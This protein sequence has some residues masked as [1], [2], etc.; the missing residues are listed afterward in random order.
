M[1]KKQW[2]IP[3]ILLLIS[4]FFFSFSCK[5]SSSANLARIEEKQEVIK[6]YPFSDPD[7]V[8]VIARYSQWA[9]GAKIYPYFFFDKYTNT[10]GADKA[11]TVVRLENPYISVAVLPQVGGKVWGATEKSSNRDFLY[12]NHVLKFR[13]IAMRGP[14]TSGGIEFNF[15][16]VGH[17]PSTATPVDY[18]NRN[19]PDGSVSCTVG[20]MDVSSRTRWSVTIRLPKDKAYFETHGAWFNPTPFSQSY[21]YWSCAAIHAADDLK[22]IFPGQFQIGHDY[23][24]PLKPWPAGDRGRDLSWYRNNDFGD[25]K[26]YFTVGEYNDFYGAWYQNSDAGFGH[27][28][29][30][31]DM[32]GRK[33]WIWDESRGGGIWVDLLTDKDGQYSEP[34][35]GRLLNQSDHEFFKPNG[36]D[37]WREIWFPYRN[38]GPMVKSSPLGVLSVD[39]ADNLFRIGVFALQDIDD[40]LVVRTP[41]N[42][43]YRERLRLKTAES[44][45]KNLPVQLGGE[46]FTVNIGE[47]LIYQSDPAARRLSRPLIF[48]AVDET[49]A[50]G[51]YLGGTR[52]EKERMY[53]AALQKYLECLSME[54]LHLRALARTAELYARRGEYQ[55]AL[56]YAEKALGN[57]M[58]DPE[59]NYIFGIISR[60]LG[61]LVDAKETL[62]WAAR[63]LEFRSSAYTQLGEISLFEKNFSQAADYARRAVDYNRYNIGAYDVMITALRKM[64]QPENAR[65]IIG[66]VL[67][68]DPLNHLARFE[69]YLLEPGTRKLMAFKSLIRNELPHEDYLEMA[70]YYQRVGCNADAATLLKNAPEY[71]TVYYWLALL[72]REKSPDESIAYLKKASELSPSLVFPFRE[73]EIPLFEWAM[74]ARPRDWKPKYYL[75][76]IYWAKGRLEETEELFKQCDDA[77][78]APFYLSRGVLFSGRNPEMTVADFEKAVR[79]NEQNWRGWHMLIDFHLRQ[80]NRE[81]ALEVARKAAKLFPED[82]P[83]QIDLVKSLMNTGGY[84]EAAIL[85]EKVNTLPYEGAREIHDL[86]AETYVQLGLKSMKKGN[87]AQAVERLE[88][89]KEYPESLGTGKPFEPDL[90][91]QDSLE[92]ICYENSGQKDKARDRLRTVSDYTLR[93]PDPLNSNSYLGGLALQRLG[94]RDKARRILARAALPPREILDWMQK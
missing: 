23:S 17:A 54:P 19:N 77:D 20:G 91:K 11:W 70:L 13:Q 44:M 82:T 61:N 2:H 72:L 8:P 35:A 36:A 87:W 71:A 59:S 78:F 86:Y 67:D 80:T 52:L 16:I 56:A 28:A 1:M 84:E 37:R 24:V 30:Y 31:D 64:N 47:K 55:K 39:T 25:S 14:W 60:R 93:N 27:W 85:L 88:K 89:A 57:S 5:S 38:I 62:G 4:S 7:P 58:Y 33:I 26:S 66:Q 21:Y 79:L 32:P 9:Q 50:E 63:S 69:A 68:I 10:A 49:T 34:Q 3:S 6:T 42:E 43:V 73:E 40:D 18:F 76:L 15:G 41:A 90:R 48:K 94:E 45:K 46:K 51:L 92:S 12:T 65:K 22:Y 81:E 53:G 29:L 83:I 74:T 75:G